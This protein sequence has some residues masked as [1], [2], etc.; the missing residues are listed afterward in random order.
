MIDWDNVRYFLAIARGAVRSAGYRLTLAG[1]EIIEFA[2]QMEASSHQLE[3]SVLG[4][5][6]TVQGLSRVTLPPFLATHLLMSGSRLVFTATSGHRD[7]CRA[8]R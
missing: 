3:T 2:I 5:D 4:R 1:R 6:Q 7:E 8:N